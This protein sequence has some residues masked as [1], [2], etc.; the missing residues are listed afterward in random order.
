MPEGHDDHPGF[1]QLR[2]SPTAL[3]SAESILLRDKAAEAELCAIFD[4]LPAAIYATDANGRITFCNRAAAELAGREPQIGTDEWCVTWRLHRADGSPLPLDQCPMAVAI[5]ENRAIR[6]VEAIL[7]RPDGSRA[8]FMPYPTPLR[9]EAG[10]LVGA[11]NMLVEM[12]DRK[13][14]ENAR[15]YL[16]AIV[17]SSDAAIISKNLSG[18]ITSWNRGAQAIFGYSA[19]E[20]IGRPV[21][22]LFPPDRM[23]EEDLILERI[24]RGERI[25]HLETVR[26]RKDGRDIDVSLTIS[27]VCDAHG[28]IIGISKIA[29]DITKRKCA[30]AALRDLNETLEK[31][32]AE[33]TRELAALNERLMTEIAERERTEAI[34]LQA[35]KME[36]MGQ[37]ASGMAHDFNNLLAA[38]LGNLELLEMRLDDRSLLRLAQAASR[39]AR[40]GA[41]LNEQ[42]LAFSRKQH[43]APK[44]VDLNR[45]IIGIDELLRRTLGGRIEI[46]T[47]TAAELWP[48][49]ADP[50]QLELV[51]LNLA[52]NARDAMPLGGRLLIETRNVEARDV[53]ASV[54][55]EPGDYVQIS[56]ADTGIGM[57]PETLERACEPFFT[58]KGPGKGSGLGLPQVYGVA[59]QSGG[60]LRLKSALGQGTTVE[61][62]LPRSLEAVPAAAEPQHA[63]MPPPRGRRARVLVVDDHEGVREVIVAYLDILGYRS[64]QAANGQEAL[65]FL[66][67]KPGAIDLLIADY[68]MPAMSGVDLLRIIRAQWPALPVVI[69]TG[70]A[71]TAEIDSR[72]VLLKKPFQMQDLGAMLELALSRQAADAEDMMGARVIPLRAASRGSA[73]D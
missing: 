12:D 29:R 28:R 21:S 11:V 61:L 51:L 3:V 18:I 40:R 24:R 66:R 62:Y 49:W 60:G 48:A 64:V 20:M 13:T 22:L 27:P 14:V 65:A 47:A 45:L 32:V 42:M 55:L 4:Q 72:M 25:E 50:H 8:R 19:A 46:A 17:D 58:T 73:G 2:L 38:I 56:V 39:S 71:E 37:L 54:G 7:E 5:K 23:A 1:R 69:V 53:D 36:A 15:L 44:P 33:R 67:G 35:Q 43:L 6:G 57:S 9:D 31:R 30:E 16:A 26:R 10:T 68:A 63:G 52:I 41:A 70:Y 59:R 34:L